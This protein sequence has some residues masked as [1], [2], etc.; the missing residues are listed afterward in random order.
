MNGIY[1]V[2]HFRIEAD[3]ASGGDIWWTTAT[4]W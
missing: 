1:D 4:S 2:I 3:A